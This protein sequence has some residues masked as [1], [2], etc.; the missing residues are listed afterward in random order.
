[1]N[2]TEAEELIAEI[3]KTTVAIYKYDGITKQ[4]IYINEIE[5]II[6]RFANKPPEDGYKIY[7]NGSWY[8][9]IRIKNEEYVELFISYSERTGSSYLYNKKS[10]TELRDNC[11]KMLEY[12]ENE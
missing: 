12:L 6:K 9:T 4:A 2:K 3:N 7:H 11:T 5:K 10:L 8:T 1:M